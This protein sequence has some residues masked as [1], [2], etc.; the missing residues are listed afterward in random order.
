M[1]LT[2]AL[3]QFLAWY[4]QSSTPVMN[5]FAYFCNHR[6]RSSRKSSITLLSGPLFP[7]CLCHNT[8]KSL[9]EEDTPGQFARVEPVGTNDHSAVFEVKGQAVLKS[10]LAYMRLIHRIRAPLRR[11][12]PPALGS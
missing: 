3:S 4:G 12:A 10:A 2:F 9:G 5:Y 8:P 11:V 6:K 7:Q 1:E